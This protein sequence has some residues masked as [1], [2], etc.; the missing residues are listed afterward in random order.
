MWVMLVSDVPQWVCRPPTWQEKLLALLLS[1]PTAWLPL[2][3]DT[4]TVQC[5]LSS[6]S[7]DFLVIAA[8]G[9]G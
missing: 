5:A 2:D 4:L 3:L 6:S 1:S 7:P 9:L 8:W